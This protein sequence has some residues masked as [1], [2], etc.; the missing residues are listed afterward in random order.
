[1]IVNLFR[2]TQAIS[3]LSIFGL[4]ISIWLCLAF[5]LTHDALEHYSPLYLFITKPIIEY[6]FINKLFTSL[7]VFWQCI[8]IN[9]MMVKQ[10]IITTNSFFPALFYFIIISASKVA[11]ALNPI[12]VALTFLILSVSIIL[13]CYLK[14]S[15]FSNIFDSS[16]LLSIAIIIHPPFL[17]FLPILWIGMS[18]FSLVELKNWGLSMIGLLSPW[19]LLYSFSTYF[20][21]VDFNPRFVL[22]FITE[23]SHY[24]A[25]ANSDLIIYSFIGLISLLALK[26]IS[27]SLSR[28]NIKSRKG[29]IM[30]LW[31]IFLSIMYLFISPDILEFKLLVFALP[32]C[33]ILSNYFYYKKNLT[34][35]NSIIYALLTL[36]LY[37]HFA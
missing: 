16:I 10:N 8:L 3:I 30:F 20:K 9:R 35:Q 5:H 29:Y 26:E 37:N 33:T 23:E 15:S 32:L 31:L 24:K 25:I 36:V 17:I 27:I 4:S 7:L 13:D 21:W 1:M 6:P 2:H 19:Y 12:L 28:K 14:K 22:K 34:L 18:I 11:T